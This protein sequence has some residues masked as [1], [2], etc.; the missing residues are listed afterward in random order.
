MTYESKIYTQL[1]I[2]EDKIKQ[3][4]YDEDDKDPETFID[5]ILV[6]LA[7]ADV[8][9]LIKAEEERAQCQNFIRVFPNGPRTQNY[10]QFLH[11]LPYFDKLLCAYEA[12]YGVNDNQRIMGIK[13]LRQLCL[14][15]YHL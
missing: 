13:K 14:K 10:H 11:K 6:D 5:R 2:E 3:E 12:T 7:P 8:R 9:Q 1:L 4:K 15:G